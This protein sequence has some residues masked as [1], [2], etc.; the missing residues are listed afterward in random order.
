MN[1]NKIFNPN[2]NHYKIIFGITCVVATMIAGFFIS[3]AGSL[4]PTSAP[5]TTTMN[6]LDD[7]Y[8]KLTGCTPAA[9]S[10]DSP[11]T[12]G[13]TMH[14]LSEIYNST[15]NYKAN[16]GNAVA[17]DVCKNAAGNY[18]TFYTSASTTAVTGTRTACASYTQVQ[19]VGTY[20]GGTNYGGWCTLGTS[21]SSSGSC[22]YLGA[23]MSGSY[24]AILTTVTGTDGSVA[25]SS[26][27]YP[28]GVC[29]GNVY[30]EEIFV[31]MNLK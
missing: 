4:N 15:P 21:C 19:V 23:W 6:T 25:M 17:A 13:S 1:L 10:L 20:D 14:T 11:G 3:R 8:C 28:Y 16:P 31:K 18:P 29:T 7:I 26:A 27:V 22:T 24:Y 12:P 30:N 9:H 2:T 5:T